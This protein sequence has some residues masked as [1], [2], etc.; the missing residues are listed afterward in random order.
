MSDRRSRGHHNLLWC[1]P[2]LLNLGLKGRDLAALGTVC[3]LGGKQTFSEF[4]V[5]LAKDPILVL[6]LGEIG[7]GGGQALLA[8]ACAGESEQN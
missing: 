8:Q 1:G 7:L 2:C 4:R 3:L 5:A 6:E